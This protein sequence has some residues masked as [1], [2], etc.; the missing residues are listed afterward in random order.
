MR[1]VQNI[2]TAVTQIAM[3]WTHVI[4]HQNGGVNKYSIQDNMSIE[5][6]FA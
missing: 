2:W 4:E 3:S 6:N 1:I 5:F